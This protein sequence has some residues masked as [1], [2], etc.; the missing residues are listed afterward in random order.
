MASQLLNEHANPNSY[1]RQKLPP[2]SGDSSSRWDPDQSFAPSSTGLMLTGAAAF[3]L[4]LAIRWLLNK[5]STS[6]DRSGSLLLLLVAIVVLVTCYY[7][8]R[9][10]WLH[11][12]RTQAVENASIL[13]TNA[14]EFDAAAHAGIVLIQEVELVSRGYN[15]CDPRHRFLG[16]G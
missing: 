4:A 12:L 8:F 1:K 2:P 15:M 10:Q 16:I 6:L 7:Y 9:H 11:Y 5:A 3:S 14:Q 13:T